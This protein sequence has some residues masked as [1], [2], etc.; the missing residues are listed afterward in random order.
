MRAASATLTRSR[1]SLLRACSRYIEDSGMYP[2]ITAITL[3]L[4][5]I[6]TSEVGTH[7]ATGRRAHE[8]LRVGMAR[9]PLPNLGL[10]TRTIRTAQQPSSHAGGGAHSPPR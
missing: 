2:V 5:T 6:V 8:T 1:P 10:L 9:A 3:T 7:A 4:V